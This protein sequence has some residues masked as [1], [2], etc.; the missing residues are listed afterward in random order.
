MITDGWKAHCSIGEEHTTPSLTTM[1]EVNLLWCGSIYHRH[2][3]N[4]W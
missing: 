1:W 2:F 4:Y 3:D